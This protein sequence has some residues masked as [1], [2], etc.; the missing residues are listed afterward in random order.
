M[1]AHAP[2]ERIATA[3]VVLRP[4]R[5]DDAAELQRIVQH[6]LGHLGRWMPWA[7]A[8]AHEDVA[9]IAA[10]LQRFADDFAAGRDWAYALE[11]RDDGALMGAV[12]LHPRRGPDALEIGY[13]IRA[14]R[15]GHGYVTEAVAALVDAAFAT[16]GI[17]RIEIRCDP[18]NLPSAAIPR[19]LGFVH[20]TTLVGDSPEPGLSRDTMVWEVRR[21]ELV[22]TRDS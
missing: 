12:G 2:P 13:W 9:Q 3:R 17:D 11:G 10:R 22:V 16:C 1:T 21:P 8:E 6:D 19:R 20:V 18:R 14:G 4:W 15:S 5:A 7:T